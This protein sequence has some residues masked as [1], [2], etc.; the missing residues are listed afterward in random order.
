[1]FDKDNKLID[2]STIIQGDLV[3]IKCYIWYWKHFTSKQHGITLKLAALN[4][5]IKVKVL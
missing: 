1:M 5:K 4:N 2:G 3:S